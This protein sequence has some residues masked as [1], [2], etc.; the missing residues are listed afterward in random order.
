M[1]HAAEKGAGLLGRADR[2]LFSDAL[3][4]ELYSEMASRPV[5]A[6]NYL[7]ENNI[8]LLFEVRLPI[9]I[10][11]CSP[12]CL[13]LQSL[14]TG[15]IYHKPADPIVF[16]QSCL[17]DVRRRDGQYTWN[18]FITTV[19]SEV[20]S[21]TVFSQSKPLPPI[22]TEPISE[23]G[24][25]PAAADHKEARTAEHGAA[26]VAQDSSGPSRSHKLSMASAA[27]VEERAG[28]LLEGK[29]LVF[30][31]GKGQHRGKENL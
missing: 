11:L 10:H 7:Y 17:D 21:R 15:L 13:T 26:M 28:G 5:L 23:A 8:P 16:L 1:F 4:R 3:K 29:P 2:A 31:L 24:S 19:G 12:I 27:I 22:H 25:Q 6:Q 14:M 20:A 18:R 30:V 9:F